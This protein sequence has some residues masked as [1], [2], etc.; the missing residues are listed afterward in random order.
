MSRC[1]AEGLN[2][3]LTCYGVVTIAAAGVLNVENQ[4]HI[5]REME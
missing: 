4:V 3:I 2:F 1:L 5:F